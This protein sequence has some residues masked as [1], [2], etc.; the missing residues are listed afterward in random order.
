VA[1]DSKGE[2]KKSGVLGQIITSVIV[3]MLVGGTSPW[4]FN[5]FFGKST[6]NPAPA[7]TTVTQEGTTKPQ[8]AATSHPEAPVK[9]PDAQ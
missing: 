5:A 9:S 3:A 6:P 7:T 2:G 8:E 4:W 1:D